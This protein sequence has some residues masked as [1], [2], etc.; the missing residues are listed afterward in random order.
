MFNVKHASPG[1]ATELRLVASEETIITL[2]E[3]VYKRHNHYLW[4]LG[5]QLDCIDRKTPIRILR[6]SGSG[7]LTNPYL[8][9]FQKNVPPK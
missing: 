4:H 3:K 6:V 5:P 2:L 1:F 9:C 8:R 7:T